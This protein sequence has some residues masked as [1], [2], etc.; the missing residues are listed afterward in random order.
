MMMSTNSGSLMFL[1]RSRLQAMQARA[2]AGGGLAR[3][4]GWMDNESGGGAG[5]WKAM[6]RRAFLPHPALILHGVSTGE[7]SNRPYNRGSN[8]MSDLSKT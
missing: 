1:E 4:A 5:Q 8:S 2:G 3:L 7:Y 6:S